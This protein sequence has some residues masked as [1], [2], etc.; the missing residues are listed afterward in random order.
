MGEV[1]QRPDGKPYRPR[2]LAAYAVTDDGD[3]LAGVMVLGTHDPGRAQPLADGYAVWQ[4]G[5][6]HVAVDPVTGWWRDGFG[7]G[8][9]C[10]VTDEVRGRAGVWF[11]EIVEEA[12]DGTSSA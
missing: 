8:H 11:R 9:R 5:S 3:M 2:K 1:I 4:L 6:G 7:Y 12:G 10:W